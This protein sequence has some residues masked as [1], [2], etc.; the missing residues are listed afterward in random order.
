MKLKKVLQNVHMSFKVLMFFH[1]G[2]LF[3]K[4]QS[5][6]V[7]SRSWMIDCLNTWQLQQIVANIMMMI[8]AVSTCLDAHVT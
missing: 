6:R 3:H 1:M 4:L 5:Q 2:M 8:V 7:E